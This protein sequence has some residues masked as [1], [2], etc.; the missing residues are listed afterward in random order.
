MTRWHHPKDNGLDLDASIRFRHQLHRHPEPPGGERE[1]HRLL[2][3]FLG[4]TLPD[5]LI[6]SIG[7]HGVAAVFEGAAPGPWVMLRA[8]TDAVPDA[9][10]GKNSVCAHRCGHDGHMAILAGVAQVV[11]KVRP[12]AGHLVLLFQPAEEDGTGARAVLEDPRFS[13]IRPEQVYALHNVPGY[14]LG[15]VIC[16]PGTM[17]FA[18]RGLHVSLIGRPAHAA[19]PEKGI[20]PARAVARIIDGLLDLP[21]ACEVNAGGGLVTIVQLN[22]GSSAYGTSAG[23][24]TLRA[25]LRTADDAIMERMVS[26]AADLVRRTA[27]SDGLK[28][29]IVWE[30]IF[31]A[32]VNE[33]TAAARVHAAA[34][35]CGLDAVAPEHPFR[36]SED[37]AHFLAFC[38]GAFFGIGAGEDVSGLHD[39][40]YE[41]PDTLIEPGVRLLLRIAE[42]ALDSRRS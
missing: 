29:R 16:R 21:S 13:A 15:T 18:S 24:A 10:T 36:W 26:G 28:D 23:T 3:Q 5:G 25:T 31:P 37:I 7:G 9:S 8:D 35:A 11:G 17:N 14:P 12:R 20:N 22:Q 33:P 34:K 41:F 32:A 4:D 38:P 2:L 30:D 39:P 27:A 19:E 1:T 6:A 40:D 42:S